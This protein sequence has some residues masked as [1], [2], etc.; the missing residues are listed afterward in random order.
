MKDY[1][2][3]KGIDCWYTSLDDSQRHYA[4]WKNSVSIDYIIPDPTY[5]TF[6][7][8]ENQSNGK[9]MSDCQRYGAGR[10]GGCDL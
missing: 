6:S 3:I 1:S 9:Q 10:R 8:R 2:G 7:K 5:M 4:E